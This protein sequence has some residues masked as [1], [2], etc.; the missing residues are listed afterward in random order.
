VFNEFFEN[1]AGLETARIF[2]NLI[3]RRPPG[4]KLQDSR[5]LR[6]LEKEQARAIKKAASQGRLKPV[7]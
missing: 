3:Q 4:W 6:C 2:F 1:A 7:K 5:V